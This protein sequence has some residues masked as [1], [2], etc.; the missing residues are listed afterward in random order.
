VEQRKDDEM[1]PM[2]S[3]MLSSIEFAPDRMGNKIHNVLHSKTPSAGIITRFANPVPYNLGFTLNIWSLHMV[4][5]DQI[6]EQILPYFAPYVMTKINIPELDSDFDVK[7]VFQSCSPDIT[8]EITDEDWRVVRW[9]M[10]FMVQSYLFKPTTDE[11]LIQ[12][13]ILK[14]YMT[15]DSW[16]NRQTY[17]DGSTETTFT[18]G[19]SG[20]EAYASTHTAY[21]PWYDAD[22]AIV[23][24]YETFGDY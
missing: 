22:A 15:E 21:S 3:V 18:S 8:H 11:K 12:Q 4:D 23:S 20:N 24:A 6:I 2:I 13:T 10:D 9:T 1:L 14:Y 16:A 17:S 7:V 19:A 5:A